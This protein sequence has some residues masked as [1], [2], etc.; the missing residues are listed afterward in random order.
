MHYFQGSKE[1]RS[2]PPPPPP[3]GPQYVPY[4]IQG[5]VLHVVGPDLDVKI[6]LEENTSYRHFVS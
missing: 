3:P 6:L 4:I 2:P 5:R 1:Q